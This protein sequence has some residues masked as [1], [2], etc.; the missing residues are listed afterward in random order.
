MIGTFRSKT[1]R[2]LWER[3]DASGVN[4]NALMRVK[5]ILSILDAGRTIRDLDVPGFRLHALRGFRPTRYSMR[6][7]ANWRIT[8]EWNDDTANAIDFEDYHGN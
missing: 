3:N 1:L 2:R 5:R 7:T 8:F 4:P 6:V